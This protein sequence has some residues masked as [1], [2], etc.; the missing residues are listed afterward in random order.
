MCACPDVCEHP[1]FLPRDVAVLRL[2]HAIFEFSVLTCK[3]RRQLIHKWGPN[4][5]WYGFC[6]VPRSTK[7]FNDIKDAGLPS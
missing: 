2:C 3:I 5:V 1:L 7:D 4:P 6:G